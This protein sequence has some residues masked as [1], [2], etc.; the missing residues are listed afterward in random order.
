M[1]RERQDV[2]ANLYSAI[3]TYKLPTPYWMLLLTKNKENLCECL[4]LSDM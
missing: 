3:F 4:R 1:N 2:V